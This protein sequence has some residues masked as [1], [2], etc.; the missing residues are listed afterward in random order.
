MGDTE[1]ISQSIIPYYD[2]TKKTRYLSFRVAG[3]AVR[4]A[5]DLTPCS[6]RSVKRWREEDEQFGH[7]DTDKLADLRKELSNEYLSVEFT[8]NF[9]LVLQK[10]FAVLYKDAMSLPLSDREHQ[11]LLKLRNHYT[12]QQLAFIKQL[13]GTIDP[14]KQFD[15][16]K[17]TFIIRREREE[18]A[19][20]TEGS[21]NP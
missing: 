4:E 9:H 8:R 3:F 14:G 11:Y 5:M 16:T 13:L 15:F 19:I 10:D 20:L 1:N 7:F 6:W 12:P 17:L 2:D 21:P 18:V